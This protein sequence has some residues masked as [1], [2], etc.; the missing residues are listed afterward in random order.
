MGARKPD[1]DRIGLREA[2]FRADPELAREYRFRELPPGLHCPFNCPALRDWYFR[3]DD[4]PDKAIHV[5]T[6]GIPGPFC[7]YPP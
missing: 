5:E 7:N 3:T 1:L 2:L 4:L 6:T